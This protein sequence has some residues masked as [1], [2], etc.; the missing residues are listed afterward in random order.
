M[1]DL[2]SCIYEGR[3]RHRRYGPAP[4]AFSYTLFMMH[5][6]L[7]ELPQVFAKSWLWSDGG[8]G[9]ARFRRRDH[10]RAAPPNQPLDAAARDLVAQ[11]LGRR[12]AGPITLLTHCEYFGYRF[13]PVSFF[14]CWT[15][16]GDRLDAIIAEINNTPWGEQHCYVLDAAGGA[17]PR[18]FEFEKQFHVSPFMG[19]DTRYIWRITPP[20]GTLGIHMDCLRDGRKFFDATLA[21]RRTA[22]TPGSLTRV[23]IQ[24]PFMTA[25]VI[26]A[27]YW[28]ALRLWLKG[29]AYHPHPPHHAAG[30][31]R[32]AASSAPD[33]S[34]SSA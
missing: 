2:R 25:R 28:E 30:P 33:A 32:H 10:L 22:I 18:A 1:T 5:L 17:G 6:D 7:A 21:L 26:A 15:D 27:I 20:A 14:F 12:P 31:P 29:C 8:W 9:V 34:E 23:L 16:G 3:V 4:H 24:H 13:N 19:M 11:R